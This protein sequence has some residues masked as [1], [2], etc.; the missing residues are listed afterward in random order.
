MMDSLSRFVRTDSLARLFTRAVDGPDDAI[1]AVAR[2]ITC[3]ISRLYWRHGMGP[4]AVAMR[5]MNDSLWDRH[6]DRYARMNERLSRY[7]GPRPASDEACGHTR[8]P[9]AA[10]S[11]MIDPRPGPMPRG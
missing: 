10:D 9:R 1:P 5:R 7:Q 4:G 11:L 6:P 2:E 3:E 8:W